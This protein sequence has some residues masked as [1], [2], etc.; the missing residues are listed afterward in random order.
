MRFELDMGNWVHDSSRR[1]RR[2]WTRL[3]FSSLD[4]FDMRRVFGSGFYLLVPIYPS[5]T[6]FGLTSSFLDPSYRKGFGVDVRTAFGKV[7]PSTCS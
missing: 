2:L 6:P 3:D 7:V 1:R 5:A 4:T